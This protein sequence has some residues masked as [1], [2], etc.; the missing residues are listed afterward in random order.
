MHTD[1]YLPD[2]ITLDAISR[3]SRQSFYVVDCQKKCFTY[4][5][6]HPLFL[7]GRKKEEVKEKGFAFYEE[8]LSP[9]DLAMFLDI[10]ERGIEL[11]HSLPLESR[12]DMVI[13]IDFR[14]R[15]QGKRLL[16]VNHKLTPIT[17]TPDGELHYALCF[18]NLS[19]SD[20]PGHAFVRLDNELRLFRYSSTTRKWVE[21]RFKALSEREKEV[22]QL[23]AEGY[24]S[25]EIAEMLFI[26]INT[27]K[28][29]RRLLFERLEVNSITKAI[30]FAENNGLI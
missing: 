24:S 7:C 9:G 4:V 15:Q 3:C 8:I 20:R 16:M 1:S 19:T 12:G 29:H 6:S 5:S 10:N 21:D 13:S 17:L 26:D 2:K 14:I 22:L 27:V 25:K 30:L 28:F 23:S 11:F 18:V